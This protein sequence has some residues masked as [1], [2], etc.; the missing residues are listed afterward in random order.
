MHLGLTGLLYQGAENCIRDQI[1]ISGKVNHTRDREGYQGAEN[2]IRDEIAIPETDND[3][4]DKSNVS[5]R[6]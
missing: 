4:S 3:N 6:R 1:T 2:C 5:G